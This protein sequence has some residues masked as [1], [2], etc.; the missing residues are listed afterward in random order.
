MCEGC[1]LQTESFEEEVGG[2]LGKHT[3]ERHRVMQVYLFGFSKDFFSHPRD[4]SGIFQLLLDEKD[5]DEN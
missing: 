1:L 3:T 5:E 2:S 4:K